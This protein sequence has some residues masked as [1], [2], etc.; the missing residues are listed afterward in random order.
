MVRSVYKYSA[1]NVLLM[2]MVVSLGIREE[3]VLQRLTES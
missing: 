2:E 1:L 3:S